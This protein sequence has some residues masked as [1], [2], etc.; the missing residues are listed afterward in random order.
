MWLSRSSASGRLPILSLLP[1]L[2]F[3]LMPGPRPCPAQATAGEIL[4]RV[5]DDQGGL[6]PQAAITVQNVATGMTRGTET[7][8]AGEYSLAA[9]PPGNYTLT[10]GKKGFAQVA[11]PGLRLEID[12]K[13]RV[14]VQLTL[15]VVSQTLN[16][17][18]PTPVLQTETAETGQVIGNGQIL[19]L[20]LLG[21]NFL[22]LTRL[23]AGVNGGAGGN[24]L[25]IAVNG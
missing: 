3:A 25:N 7:S 17:T 21:R 15:G 11:R 12:Q 8:A 19:D 24:T 20:P 1:L 13:M 9:L 16:V 18:A 10:I 14:D 6:V 22:D 4:G 2:A 5:L 23:T